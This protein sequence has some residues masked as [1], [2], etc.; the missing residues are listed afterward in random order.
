MTERQA[1]ITFFVVVVLFEAVLIGGLQVL[2][3]DSEM[4]ATAVGFLL[5][6]AGLGVG[7]LGVHYH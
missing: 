4:T 7:F 3:A 5:C 2:G 6:G 1:F